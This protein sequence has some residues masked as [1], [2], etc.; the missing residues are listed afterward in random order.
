MLNQMSVLRRIALLLGTAIASV[1]L[2][3][4]I[5]AVRAHDDI[6][7]SRREMLQTA[8][9]PLGTQVLELQQQAGSGKLSEDVA[10]A[11]SMREQALRLAEAVSAFRLG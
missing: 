3:V 6:M 4:V 11:Q 5:N 8:L 1:L 7:A 10:A 2:L 9:Q